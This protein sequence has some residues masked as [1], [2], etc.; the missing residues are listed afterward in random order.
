M[1]ALSTTSKLLYEATTP[2]SLGRL[3]ILIDHTDVL[4]GIRIFFKYHGENGLAP[5]LRFVRELRFFVKDPILS[6]SSEL[7]K[8]RDSSRT[9]GSSGQACGVFPKSFGHA[10]RLILNGLV[11]GKLA[12][13]VWEFPW[14]PG[15]VLGYNGYIPKFQPQ[16]DAITLST[17]PIGSTEL[18]MC[19]PSYEQNVDGLVRLKCLR[20]LCW[21]GIHSRRQIKILNK[22]LQQ[23]SNKLH[24]LRL[25]FSKQAHVDLSHITLG[26]KTSFPNLHTI[27]LEN[28]S[29]SL[30]DSPNLQSL[31]V[32]GCADVSYL[33]HHQ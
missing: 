16:L 17:P 13:F 11:S 15:E 12:A 19:T 31:K 22:C 20:S 7:Q 5:Y 10:A 32:P 28:I 25:C 24:T 4:S 26:G 2:F 14:L 33:F 27:S 8:L 30:V 29:T 23:N 3:D 1:R 9:L 21:N 6:H 18:K